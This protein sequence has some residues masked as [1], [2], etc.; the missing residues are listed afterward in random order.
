MLIARWFKTWSHLLNNYMILRFHVIEFLTGV[1]ISECVFIMLRRVCMS[2][3]RDM[4]I[5][6][7]RAPPF[8]WFDWSRIDPKR[9][10]TQNIRIIECGSCCVIKCW[11]AKSAAA[12]LSVC[13]P[14]RCACAAHGAYRTRT[15]P[16]WSYAIKRDDDTITITISI[17]IGIT[18]AQTEPRRHAYRIAYTQTQKHTYVIDID[19]GLR[20]S[21][22]RVVRMC[23][24]MSSCATR[25]CEKCEL[26]F[27]LS[28]LVQQVFFSVIRCS[29][30]LL[31]NKFRFVL[32]IICCGD[33]VF[34]DFRVWNLNIAC[35]Q[36]WS[37]GCSK[38]WNKPLGIIWN[39]LT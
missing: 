27:F 32:G 33:F 16:K 35:A 28:R 3:V 14:F 36:S 18:C 5:P 13:R 24:H 12:G 17:S 8:R 30:P 10:R 2:A 9:D 6:A 38:Q 20:V 26:R 19:V 21:C 37:V 39:S 29:R 7:V 11:F 15:H 34:S 1:R 31:L 23:A 25:A 22:S 4:F